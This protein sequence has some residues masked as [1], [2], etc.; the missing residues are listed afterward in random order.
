MKPFPV[1]RI[2]IFLLIT[3]LA[4]VSLASAQTQAKPSA[5]TATKTQASATKPADAKSPA[6]SAG[7]AFSGNAKAIGQPSAGATLGARTR[8]RVIIPSQ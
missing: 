2:G 5:T 8:L 7:P 6:T 3:M 4:G 1:Y